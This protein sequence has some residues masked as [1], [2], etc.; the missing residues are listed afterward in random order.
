MS[1][2]TPAFGDN[3]RIRSTELTERLGLAGCAGSVYGE[4]KPS[5]TGVEVIGETSSDFAVNVMLDARGEQLCF[6]PELVEFVDH[7]P[8]IEVKI[9]NRRLVRAASGEWRET[10]AAASTDLQ[11]ESRELLPWRGDGTPLDYESRQRR[12]SM[13]FWSP[14]AVVWVFAIIAIALIGLLFIRA[15]SGP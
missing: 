12:R 9:G 1:E 8:G 7:A 2:V 3:V 6:A 11:Y 10:P 5:V 13:W 14:L 15:L 4:T